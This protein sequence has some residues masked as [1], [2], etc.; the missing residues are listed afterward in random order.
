MGGYE[1]IVAEW[2]HRNIDS[3]ADLATVMNE[4]CIS[5]AYNSSKIENVHVTYHDTREIFTHDSVSN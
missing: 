3:G 5:F 1:Q 4:R 2:Q